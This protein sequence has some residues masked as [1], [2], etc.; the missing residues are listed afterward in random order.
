MQKQ[1]L[2]IIYALLVLTVLAMLAQTLLGVNVQEN[3]LFS[4][5][6]DCSEVCSRVGDQAKPYCDSPYLKDGPAALCN[7]SWSGGKCNGS[8]AVGSKCAL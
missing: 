8:R 2:R 4:N 5:P 7:C 3:F 6:Q 1:I